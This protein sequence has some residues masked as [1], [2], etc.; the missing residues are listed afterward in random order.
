MLPQPETDKPENELMT[1]RYRCTNN[2]NK[3]S[4]MDNKTKDDITDEELIDDIDHK[5][6]QVDNKSDNNEHI[7]EI[8]NKKEQV[9]DN[10]KDIRQVH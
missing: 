8:D 7:D 9:D 1:D 6:E 2:D 3:Y 4:S 10:S 5:K